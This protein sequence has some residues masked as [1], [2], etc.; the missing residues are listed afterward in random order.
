MST[1]TTAR[2]E[3]RAF[4]QSFGIA[5]ETIRLLA[6][7]RSITESREVYL[8]QR[9]RLDQNLKIRDG[10]LDVKRLIGR[11]SGLEQWQPVAKFPFP[12]LPQ[13]LEIAFSANRPPIELA[14][15]QYRL[16]RLLELVEQSNDLL[17]VNVF[18]RRFRFVIKECFVEIDE[19][20]V[21]G[22]SIRSIAI[23]SEDAGLVSTLRQLVRLDEYDNTSYLLALSRIVGFEPCSDLERYA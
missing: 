15:P 13:D 21:N 22:A 3:F 6:S 4:A 14:E 19:V 23:E 2:F 16:Q 10:H 20:L 7:C 18:K 8:L 1:D 9:N 11:Q 5:E 17:R 12:V